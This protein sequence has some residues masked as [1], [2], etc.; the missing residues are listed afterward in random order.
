MTDP[1]REQGPGGQ[2]SVPADSSALLVRGLRAGIFLFAGLVVI[3]AA[4]SV[5]AGIP[6]PLVFALVGSALVIEYAAV[7]T[8]VALQVPP[9]IT[10]T[11][12]FST[13]LGIIT[14]SLEIFDAFSLTSPR[15]AGFLSRIRNRTAGRF[16]QKYGIWGL[17][18]AIL[19][20]GFYIT[21]GLSFIF[22]LPKWR[23]LAIMAGGFLLGELVTL[24]VT[25]GVLKIL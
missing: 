14:G 23:S 12:V 22:G 16:M 17:V 4:I 7:V 10:V 13:A 2:A 1:F 3:P 6:Y 21:P 5:L 25:T 24:A 15:L 11:V 8:G 20:A 19:V 9:Y 18:P